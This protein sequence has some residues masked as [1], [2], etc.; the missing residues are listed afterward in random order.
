MKRLPIKRAK[1]RN[2]LIGVGMRPNAVGPHYIRACVRRTTVVSHVRHCPSTGVY[3]MYRYRALKRA[4]IT[5]V[6]RKD[7]YKY[8][9]LTHHLFG[10]LTILL[11]IY[12]Q[13][14]KNQAMRLGILDQTM[15]PT[16]IK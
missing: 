15:A 13:H 6:G 4:Q 11:Y 12:T 2:I 5:I 10:N 9:H 1:K 16:L 14:E 7:I 8:P 3:S